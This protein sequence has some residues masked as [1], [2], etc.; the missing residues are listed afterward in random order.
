MGIYDLPAAID[1]VISVTGHLKVDIAGVSLGGTIPLIT[2]AEKPQYNEKIRNLVLM[3]PATRMGSQWKGVQYFF[4]RKTIQAFLVNV[5]FF[6]FTLKS[7][8]T[9]YQLSKYKTNNFRFFLC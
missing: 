7:I 4:I 1:L 6:Y 8:Q 5:W 3:A 9:Q 2:L